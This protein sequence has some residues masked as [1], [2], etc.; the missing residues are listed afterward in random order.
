MISSVSPWI[1]RA[2]H[3]TVAIDG[4]LPVQESNQI[5]DNEE[6][7]IGNI[8]ETRYWKILKKLGIRYWKILKKLGTRYWKILIKETRYWSCT[9]SLF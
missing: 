4:I 6:L 9:S 3:R 8:K 7:V 5:H 2:L 1:P